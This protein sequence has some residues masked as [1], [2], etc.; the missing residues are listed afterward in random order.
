MWY[1]LEHSFT[2]IFMTSWEEQIIPML[3][4]CLCFVNSKKVGFVFTKLNSLY[5][6]I[7]LNFKR[8]NNGP[9]VHV[10]RSKFK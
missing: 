4:S 9:D 3:T 1:S 7:P 5:L 6:N 2:K 10:K 8:T